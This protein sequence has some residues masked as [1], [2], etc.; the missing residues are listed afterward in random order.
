MRSVFSAW[1]PNPHF[2]ITCFPHNELV[3][4]SY[5]IIEPRKQ[6][7]EQQLEFHFIIPPHS[8]Q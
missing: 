4:H 6:E 8:I 3:N 1:K 7:W 5:M 2:V